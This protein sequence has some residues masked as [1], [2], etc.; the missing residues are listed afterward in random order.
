MYGQTLESIAMKTVK[1]RH[2]T[3][4]CKT[5]ESIAMKSVQQRNTQHNTAIQNTKK[6]SNNRVKQHQSTA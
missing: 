2:T 5:L 4:H 1:Q 3:T 6:H